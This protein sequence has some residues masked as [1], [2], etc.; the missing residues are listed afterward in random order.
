MLEDEGDEGDGRVM[1]GWCFVTNRGCCMLYGSDT[2]CS[3][4][5]IVFLYLCLKRIRV[6]LTTP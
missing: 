5:L 6:I 1:E 4:I 2:L 3:S